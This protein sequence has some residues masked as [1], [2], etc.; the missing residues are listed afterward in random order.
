MRLWRLRFHSPAWA[1]Y[2]ALLL[3]VSAA[4][5][6]PQPIPFSH[7]MHVGLGLKCDGCHTVPEPG[8][9]ATYPAESKCMECHAAVKTESPAIRKLSDFYKLKKPVPW[10]RIYRIPDFVWFSHRVH[11]KNAKIS[12]ETCHGPVAER[13]VIVKEKLID[14]AS[15]MFCHDQMGASL[16]CNFCHNP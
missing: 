16:A 13:D 1:A 12:C 7:K 2:L 15:C 8:D 6:K 9:L 3:P 14:M 5:P 10:V 4:A 11:Y